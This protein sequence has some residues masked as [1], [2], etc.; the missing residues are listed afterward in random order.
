MH[1]TLSPQEQQDLLRNLSLEMLS[2]GT[3][4]FIKDYSSSVGL[5]AAKQLAAVVAQ[6]AGLVAVG[7]GVNALPTTSSSQSGQPKGT[8]K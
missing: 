2:V 4:Q 1:G 7:A 5:S 8:Q 3:D 6:Q